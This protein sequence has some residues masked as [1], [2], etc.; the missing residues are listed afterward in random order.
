MDFVKADDS[1]GNVVQITRCSLSMSIQNTPQHASDDGQSCTETVAYYKYS[2][3]VP[4]QSH[5]QRSSLIYLSQPHTVRD[6]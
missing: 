6:L 5:L 4:V 1:L 2:R 3:V